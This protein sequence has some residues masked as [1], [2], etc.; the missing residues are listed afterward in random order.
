[1]YG[2]NHGF[3]RFC[4][5]S[6]QPEGVSRLTGIHGR[7]G[8]VQKQHRRILRGDH[9]EKNSLKFAARK[10]SHRSG[11]QA[12][13]VQQLGG[14]GN[15]FPVLPG[16]ASQQ[17]SVGN[18]TEAD[19]LKDCKGRLGAEPLSGDAQ[20]PSQLPARKL[21]QFAS[22]Q[23]GRAVIWQKSG[24]CLEERAFAAAV[25]ADEGRDA[26]GMKGA[27]KFLQRR[28]VAVGH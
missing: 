4:P 1:M 3:S 7:R 13:D 11:E 18:S 16:K 2:G 27:R 10:F 15:Q 25:G 19:N 22:S 28:G 8:F 26:S 17:R 12:G 5:F 14:C 20:Q 6:H 23:Q 9:R 21:F 24:E